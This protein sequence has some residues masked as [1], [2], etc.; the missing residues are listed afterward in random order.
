MDF[1]IRETFDSATEQKTAG[2]K[3]RID[4]DYIFFREIGNPIV[5][6]IPSGY[7]QKGNLLKKLK[8]QFTALH[9]WKRATQNL[10]RGDRLFIQ[11]PFLVHSFFLSKVFR[12]LKRRGVE[13]IFLVHDLTWVQSASAFHRKYRIKKERRQFGYADKYIIHNEKMAEYLVKNGVAVNKLTVLNLFDYL[14][15]RCGA[16]HGSVVDRNLPIIIAGNLSKSK[17]GYI[18]SLPDSVEWNLYGPNYSGE[19]KVNV[20]YLGA[21]AP[22]E[23]VDKMSGSYGLVW[24][25]DSIETC[26]GVTGEYLRL[27]NPHKCSLYLALGIPVIIWA[28]AALAEFVLKNKCGIAVK[29]LSD[30]KFEIQKISDENYQVMRDNAKSIAEKLQSGYYTK[31]AISKI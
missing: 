25:G 31:T 27:N 15:P 4:V 2:A 28:Q 10:K 3:A 23:L 22:D 8:G 1:F 20:S 9:I 12:K 16:E 13:L 17:S 7:G 21:F 30:I 5:L 14:I 19:S 29:S 6:K 24:D 11:F 26:A 18:Y